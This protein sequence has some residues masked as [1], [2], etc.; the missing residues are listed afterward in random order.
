MIT[1]G[2][3]RRL[4]PTLVIVAILFAIGVAVNLSE[5]QSA[6]SLNTTSL[7]AQGIASRI[8]LPAQAK[9][10]HGIAIIL[11]ID[12][13]GS[14]RDPAA[15]T[16]GETKVVA[17]RRVASRA[18]EQIG[19]F[20]DTVTN[21]PVIAAVST[22]ST[23]VSVIRRFSRP[24]RHSAEQEIRPLIANGDT[25]IGDALIDA[26]AGLNRSGLARQYIIVITD[27][28]NTAGAAP[29][30]V[31]DAFR[32]LPAAYQPSVYVIAFDID[33]GLFKPLADRGA[34]VV[35]ARNAG[36]LQ[37]AIDKILYGSILVESPEGMSE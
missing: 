34:T 2:R 18:L 22:F 10:T 3:R 5:K 19:D 25:A 32:L 35:E 13:S 27:G 8:S 21:M 12:V 36:Q 20:A 4:L 11:T 9:L 30:T 26:K 33:A 24:S 28:R 16:T 37:E 31:L 17:A 6:G 7:S 15:G 1:S 23:R 14:M 29:D